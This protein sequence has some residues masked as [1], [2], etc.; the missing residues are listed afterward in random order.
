MLKKK[1]NNPFSL[2]GFVSKQN[3]CDRE[4]EIKTLRE[5]FNNERNVVL[6]SWRR[7]GK[8]ML[9]KYFMNLM[10][11]EKKAETLY[12]DLMPTKDI[13]AAIK[14]ITIA[15]H[16]KFGRSTSGFSAS[17]QKLLGSI[18]MDVSFD[19]T[20]GMPVFSIGFRSK[21]DY[22]NSLNAIGTFLESRKT[23]VLV[24]L[25]EFQQVANYEETNGEAIFRTWMQHFPSLQFIYSGSHRTLMATMFSEK[26]RPFYR[27]AQLLQLN[28]IDFDVYKKFIQKHFKAS[29]K[30]ISAEIIKQIYSWSRGQTYCVQLI[31]NRLYANCCDEVTNADLTEVFEE[32][33]EDE[34]FIFSYYTNML[35]HTQWKVLKAIAMEEPL[36][37]PTGKDFIQ[38]HNLG[39]ASTVSTALQM[40]MK[41][42][43]VIQDE[44]QYFVHD[45]M[46]ARWL[47]KL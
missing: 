38:K 12:I 46:M 24:V 36:E 41:N 19:P 16:E 13:E 42:E 39:A 23:K 47:Q 35:T 3:F 21:V 26:N 8:T 40:L 27:S 1:I 33:L 22:Q 17:F 4:E 30:S 14:Q 45:V 44:H 28:P 34:R 9:I 31:C 20:T 5:H 2:K 43:I 18:G 10:E 25:D 11:T 29:G 7:M 6:F 37:K 15:V 32:I